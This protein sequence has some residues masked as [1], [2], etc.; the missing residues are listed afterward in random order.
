MI[1]GIVAMT[2]NGV[3]GV[4]GGIPW[5]IKEDMKHFKETTTGHTVIMG[6]TTWESLGCKPLPNRNNIIVSTT[7]EPGQHDGATFTNSLDDAIRVAQSECCDTF[8][9][10][11]AGLY[12]SAWPLVEEWIVTEIPYIINA[13]RATR[14]PFSFGTEFNI[15]SKVIIQANA[16]SPVCQLKI[17]TYRKKTHG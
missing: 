7:A 13:D 1:K 9:I 2:L 3:I 6:R 4:D 5:D 14:F 10:G 11:G 15:M 12:K 8:I 17:V 16:P